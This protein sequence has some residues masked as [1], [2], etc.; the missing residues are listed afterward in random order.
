MLVV[1]FEKLAQLACNVGLEWHAKSSMRAVIVGMQFGDSADATQ[2]VGI[3]DLAQP[4][5]RFVNRR[6]L[7]RDTPTTLLSK[8]HAVRAF[9][10][11]LIFGGRYIER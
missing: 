11:T 4:S 2:Q 3:F 1:P 9:K 8:A 7:G 10:S 5:S 6:W